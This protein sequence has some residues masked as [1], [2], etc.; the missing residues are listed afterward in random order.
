MFCKQVAAAAG[1]DSR[2][3][4]ARWRFTEITADSFHWIGKERSSNSDPWQI[5]YEHFARR[6]GT[7]VSARVDDD[8]VELARS[9]IDDKVPVD[10]NAR[11]AMYREE[12]W[13]GFDETSADFTEEELVRERERARDYRP[14]A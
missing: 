5:T 7:L 3:L 11:R 12:G 10:L 9:I 1:D 4:K 6:G 14:M 8:Q 13:Q 2:G